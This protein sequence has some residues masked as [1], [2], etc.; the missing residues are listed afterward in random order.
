MN[1]KKLTA[2]LLAALMLTSSLVACDNKEVKETEAVETDTPETDAVETEAPVIDYD[3]NLV[4]KDGVATAHIVVA[5]DADPLLT[6]AA[7]ELVYHIQKVSGGAVSIASTAVTGSLPIIIAT[8]DT[9]PELNELFPEDIA[10]LSTLEEDGKT[11]GSDGFAVRRLDKKLYIFGITPRGALNGVYDFIEDNMGVLWTRAYEEIGL[12]Y[13]EM[14]TIT[15]E[16]ADYREKS[17][18]ETRGWNLYSNSTTTT[19]TAIMLSRNKLNARLRVHCPEIG[20]TGVNLNHNAKSW[21]LSSP[22][23]DPNETEYW[24]TDNVGNRLTADTSP[25]INFWSDLTVDV[26]AA[27][28]IAA[29]DANYVE[30]VG[31]GTEDNGGCSVLP[32]SSEPFEYAPGQ[33]VQPNDAAYFSTVFFAFLNKVAEKVNAVYPEVKIYA[34]AYWLT[35]KAPLC[36][37]ADSIAIVFASTYELNHDPRGTKTVVTEGHSVRATLDQWLKFAETND[38]CIYNYYGCSRAMARYE[39]PL[40]NRI[41]TELTFYA[42]N[43]FAGV[44]PEG[45]E[46][47]KDSVYP[48]G[49][50]GYT[51]DDFWEMSGLTFWIYS[52]LAWN[53]NEDVDA[54]IRYFCDKV[55][56]T[57]A[58]EHMQNYYQ[59]LEKG[60]EECEKKRIIFQYADPAKKYIDTFVAEMGLADAMLTELRTAY[61]KAETDLI[62]ERIRPILESYVESFPEAQ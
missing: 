60:W 4:T 30:N 28:M 42:E 10:W 49:D 17:P 40:W 53:P 48:I 59:L 15:V 22:L 62:K 2:L 31:L 26:V 14:P 21:V 18:F 5:E 36:D 35:E 16:K 27:G 32:L 24:C 33:F 57:A 9:Y 12:V 23:Y 13:D 55:Y 50:E 44:L 37:L 39:R 56:G 38:I 47:N 41:Q 3:E 34:F 20:V 11:Y 54:L 45:I 61:D 51:C 46:D 52:K 25:Q 6:Y 19:P 43:N 8:P 7:E 1:L 58:S 29:L